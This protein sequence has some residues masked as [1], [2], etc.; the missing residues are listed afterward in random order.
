MGVIAKIT[1]ALIILI[2]ICIILTCIT[3]GP[4][5]GI[6]MAIYISILS[7][8]VFVILGVAAALSS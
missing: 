3:A 1:I 8:P 4:G 7:A 2:I 5:M 6:F